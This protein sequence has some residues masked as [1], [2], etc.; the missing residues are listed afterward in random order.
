MKL[1]MA[2]SLSHNDRIP[3][4]LSGPGSPTKMCDESTGGRTSRQACRARRT[5]SGTVLCLFAFPFRNTTEPERS[6]IITSFNSS[7]TRSPTRQP[8]NKNTLTMAF[9]PADGPTSYVLRKLQRINS[10]EAILLPPVAGRNFQYGS[11]H[12]Q[13][14]QRP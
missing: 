12:T 10:L 7:D 11:G 13:G 9:A 2:E 8:V 3:R 1:Q 6:P 14:R 5:G 4:S